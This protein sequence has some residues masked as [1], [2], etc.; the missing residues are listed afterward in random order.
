EFLNYYDERWE[1]YL[2]PNIKGNDIEEIKN[3]YNTDKVKFL[4]DKVH[5]KYS[6]SHNENRT[7]HHCFYEVDADIEG[8]YF[9]L[10]ELLKDEK[11]KE[12]N[13]D[14]ITFIK[15]YYNI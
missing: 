9:T 1:M 12:N 8:E 4:F 6:V 2:F 3:K 15:D 14:I 7:Y 11:V 13:S 5:D 10:D